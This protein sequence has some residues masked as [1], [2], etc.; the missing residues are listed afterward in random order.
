MRSLSALHQN[1]KLQLGLACTLLVGFS[2]SARVHSTL[3]QTLVSQTAK[4][5]VSRPAPRLLLCPCSGEDLP[6]GSEWAQETGSAWSLSVFKNI[7]KGRASHTRKNNTEL[8]T[9]N[10]PATLVHS[11]A[12]PQ[13]PLCIVSHPLA[14]PTTCK[15]CA[16]MPRPP[17]LAAPLPPWNASQP[18]K[19]ARNSQACQG[20][21]PVGDTGAFAVERPCTL[22]RARGCSRANQMPAGKAAPCQCATGEGVWDLSMH[23]VCRISCSPYGRVGCML[24]CSTAII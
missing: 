13:S 11:D 3:R 12:L 5:S 14:K 1:R 6:P 2:E 18:K 10:S 22:Q 4:C 9:R 8:R 7:Y 23:T 20:A 21:G 19:G 24:F 15:L 17:S 16:S